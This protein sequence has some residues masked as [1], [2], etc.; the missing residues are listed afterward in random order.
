[1]RIADQR[2][3]GLQLGQRDVDAALG[4]AVGLANDDVLRHVHQTTGQVTRVGG[5]KS[6]VRQTLSGAV[7]VDEVL[8]HRQALTER[9]LDRTRDELTLRVG[10]QTLHAGQR[11]RLGE[12]TRGTGVDDRDDRVVLRVVRPQ[13]LTDLFGRLLPDLHQLAVALVVVERAALVLLLDPVGLALVAVEDLLL[14]RRHDHVG[15]RHGDTRTGGPVEAGVLELVHGLRDHDHR[16]ALGQIV[17]DP[18][19]HL[20][21]HLLVDERIPEREQLVEHHPAQ[22]G[23]C[24]PGVARL[25]T[26]VAEQLGLDA[27][28]ADAAGSAAP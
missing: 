24:G 15:H 9:G 27:R 6:G 26:L 19:L 22:R 7:G 16:V 17:D 10:H 12:V 4:L 23:L 21:V 8:Q 2:A 1:M 14:L 28:R 11:A 3:V 5:T 13:R 18:R 25:P 20:L